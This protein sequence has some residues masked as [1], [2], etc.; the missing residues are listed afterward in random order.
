MADRYMRLGAARNLRPAQGR[1]RFTYRFPTTLISF[2]R[3]NATADSEGGPVRL[4]LAI[5]Q[6]GGEW[7]IDAL[8]WQYELPPEPKRR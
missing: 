7:E 8:V 1:L 5:G 4:F 2:G 6:A 3:M